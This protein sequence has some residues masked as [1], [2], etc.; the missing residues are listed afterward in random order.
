MRE[1]TTAATACP[2]CARSAGRPFVE[3]RDV[4]VQ[5]NI[6]WET[7]DE[8][9]SA[10]RA[11][12]AL[13]LCEGCGLIWNVAF[14]PSLLSYGAE[15]ENSLHF[16][17]AFQRYCESLVDRLAARYPL[18]GR[19]VTEIGSGKGEF[20][21]LLCERTGCGGIGFDPSYAGEADDRADGRLTFVRDVFLP[22]DDLGGADLVVSRHVVEHLEKPLEMLVAIREA[23]GSRDAAIYVEVP[24]TEYL[25]GEDAVWDFIYPHV[26]Y[27]TA[28]ALRELVT[29]ADFHVREHGFGFGGQYLWVEAS[30]RGDVDPGGPSPNGHVAELTARFSSR[31]AAKRSEWTEALPELRARGPIVLW[32]AGAKGT[33][34]LN[35]VD[36]DGLVDAVVDVNPRKHGHFVP[37][38]GQPIVAPDTLASRHPRTVVVMNPVYRPEIEERMRELGV[39]AEVVV[40]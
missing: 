40:A 26:T 10:P 1:E 34:Y 21:A 31:L 24:A 14:D 11:H 9:R 30:T 4:P 2:V 29:R 27:F 17:P 20:L 13:A 8:A 6:L 28:P 23:L 15:Y 25:L 36:T 12:L 7:A 33:T 38:T 16:S 35:V 22:G 32:G 5:P 39:D 37:G 3:L 18:R 19:R